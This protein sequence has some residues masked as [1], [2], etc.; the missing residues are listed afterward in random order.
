MGKRTK[1]TK[2][3][4]GLMDLRKVLD[5]KLQARV[6][7]LGSDATTARET[8]EG[9]AQTNSEIGIKHEFG[10]R[11][12]KIP[13]RSF[14]REPIQEKFEDETVKHKKSFKKSFESGNIKQ[15]YQKLAVIAEGIVLQAFA[16][17]GFGK[18]APNT[19]VTVARKGSDTPL[20]DTAQLRKSIT[21]DV[22][23]L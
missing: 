15:V 10:V 16:T 14:L 18:W 23:A 6:G 12:E 7:I 1:I 13:K 20:I 4:S 21:S 17:A 5:A 19:A 22:K 8:E 3:F 11:G 2:N 9:K